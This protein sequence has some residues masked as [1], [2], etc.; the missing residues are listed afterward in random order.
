MSSGVRGS[1]NHLFG[2][3]VKPVDCLI[4]LVASLTELGFIEPVVVLTEPGF[5][6]RLKRLKWLVVWR[7]AN[8]EF[9]YV[10]EVWQ[11][12]KCPVDQGF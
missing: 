7:W 8:N 2:D 3:R 6:N 1:A 4:E 10:K 12:G 9:R 5:V 11:T